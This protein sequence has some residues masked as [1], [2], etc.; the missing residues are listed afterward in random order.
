MLPL[1]TPHK[2]KTHYRAFYASLSS[3]NPKEIHAQTAYK[4]DYEE[5][6]SEYP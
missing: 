1:K 2:Q 3:A 5:S 6:H 4:G